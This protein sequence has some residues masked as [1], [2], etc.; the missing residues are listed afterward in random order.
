M[1][2]PEHRETSTGSTLNTLRSS[3]G[4]R[5]FGLLLFLANCRA[6]RSGEQIEIADDPQATATLEAMRKDF[7]RQA[8]RSGSWDQQAIDTILAKRDTFLVDQGME[9]RTELW[10]NVSYGDGPQL[11][12][13]VDA[14]KCAKATR[15]RVIR[16]T[17]LKTDR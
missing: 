8:Q 4:A 11:Q 17:E 14:E 1:Q 12:I 15:C 16:A 7:E 3:I 6:E 2:S 10:R 13:E 5:A 9:P